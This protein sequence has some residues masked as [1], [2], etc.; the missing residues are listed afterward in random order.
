[1]TRVL[2]CSFLTLFLLT[3]LPVSSAS[4]EASL[5]AMQARLVE[6]EVL[7]ADFRQ[8]KAM[9]ALNR[10][11]VSKG[12]IV[13][14]AGDGVLWQVLEPFA[15]QILM[16]SGA[17]TEWDAEGQK[18]PGN[19]AANPVL[20]ALTD[21]VLGVL[22][23]NEDLLRQHFAFSAQPE[24]QGWQLTLQPKSQE[25]GTAVTSVQ[26]SGDRFVESVH[27][28]EARGDTTTIH[29][30]GFSTTPSELDEREKSYFAR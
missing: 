1:M 17:V 26:V 23:G 21:V 13:F 18:R 7:R 2:A 16:R 4:A 29:F 20:G 5:A 19:G 12:K 8:E 15:S 14:V 28:V 3:V 30:S 11:L 22:S 6:T 10:P 9:Q 24:E 27:V 25:L